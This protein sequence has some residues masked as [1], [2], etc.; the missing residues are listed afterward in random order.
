MFG[1]GM[2]D[3]MSESERVLVAPDGL[4][5]TR[6]LGSRIMSAQSTHARAACQEK[7][8]RLKGIVARL[9]ESA[10]APQIREE[11][12]RVGFGAVNTYMLVVVRNELFPDRP[13]RGGG[14]RPG[15]IAT[16]MGATS[17]PKCESYQTLAVSKYVRKDGMVRRRHDCRACGHEFRTVS[18]S[19]VQLRPRSVD[20]IAALEATEKNCACCKRVLPVACF[21]ARPSRID[22]PAS[23]TRSLYRSHCKDCSNEK[24]A[25]HQLKTVLGAFGLSVADHEAMLTRQGGGC[26]IC[27]SAEPGINNKGEK[28]R[29]VFCIDHCHKT[30]RVRGLLCNRCNLGIGNFDDDVSRL[31]AAANYLRDSV[32]LPGGEEV[33]YG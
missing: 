21:G 27:G 26:A 31:E 5:T 30:G 24:R 18:A 3:K 1:A 15:G 33:T 12:Y 7:R 16:T 10:T 19:N 8:D 20:R 4:Y 22:D 2:A 32:R 17:C 28:A 11:A 23:G 14:K 29:R 13:K 9:G 25:A 6:L